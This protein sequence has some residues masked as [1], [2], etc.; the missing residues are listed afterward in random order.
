MGTSHPPGFPEGEAAI[1]EFILKH[2][3]LW[4]Q[5]RQGGLSEEEMDMEYSRHIQSEAERLEPLMPGILAP[6]GARLSYRSDNDRR[7]DELL[8]LKRPTGEELAEI[9]SLLQAETPQVDQP[10]CAIAFLVGA[11]GRGAPKEAV[12]VLLAATPPAER[13]ECWTW[14]GGRMGRVLPNVHPGSPPS[15]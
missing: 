2:R 12:D 4:E 6:L 1:E 15:G 5:H 10:I 11:L 14:E 3:L 13:S 9:Q 7:L 8:R